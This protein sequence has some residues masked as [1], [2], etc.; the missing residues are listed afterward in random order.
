MHTFVIKLHR[1]HF[2]YSKFISS[3]ALHSL[4]PRLPGFEDDDT[5]LGVSSSIRKALKR[6][7]HVADTRRVK[8]KQRASTRKAKLRGERV[9]KGEQSE[10]KEEGSKEVTECE[11]A[12]ME[13]F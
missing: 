12:P 10:G 7:L 13:I 1:S 11:G 9:A 4:E 6:G 2:L 8:R 5:V 3:T